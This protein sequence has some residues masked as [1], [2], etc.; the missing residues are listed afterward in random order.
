MHR[1]FI[2]LQLPDSFNQT[3]A[4]WRMQHVDW[5]VRWTRATDLHLTVIAPWEVASPQAAI[6]AMQSLNG[7]FQPQTVL[8]DVIKFIHP[9]E[10][11][12]LWVEGQPSTE[13]L[14]MKQ[15]LHSVFERPNEDQA[16]RPHVTIAR[17][18]ADQVQA[19]KDQVETISWSTT[20]NALVLYESRI[21]H[22]GSRYKA[23]AT[24]SA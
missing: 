2:G 1:L 21:D 12:M 15:R 9:D 16:F 5:P 17:C 8:F 11:R 7:F 3:L 23:L 20:C 4:T 14:D 13:L 19:L 24:V 6:N 10:P 18:W 22:F